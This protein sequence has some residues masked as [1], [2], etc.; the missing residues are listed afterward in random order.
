MNRRRAGYYF[1]AMTLVK[2]SD[3]LSAA[4]QV[5]HRVRIA[6]S[7]HASF[8]STQLVELPALVGMGAWTEVGG[9]FS[10]GRRAFTVS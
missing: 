2:S 4:V 9:R 10:G 8:V 7:D 5:Q 1:L 3:F 6:S